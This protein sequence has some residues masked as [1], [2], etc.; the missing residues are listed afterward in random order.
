MVRR[1]CD[2]NQVEVKN[3]M[4]ASTTTTTTTTTTTPNLSFANG[5]PRSVKEK[6]DVLKEPVQAVSYPDLVSLISNFFL[7]DHKITQLLRSSKMK[8]L[9]ARVAISQ[10]EYPVKNIL[11]FKLKI[12]LRYC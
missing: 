6:D 8:R 5:R 3:P 2:F 12:K 10:I 4:A 11:Q 1:A 9:N 7:K